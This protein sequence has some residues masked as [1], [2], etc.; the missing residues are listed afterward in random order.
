MCKQ[1]YVLKHSAA[2]RH[3]VQTLSVSDSRTYY[4]N[5]VR[6]C[7]MELS[8]YLSDIYSAAQFLC[9]LIKH[10]SDINYMLVVR[11]YGDVVRI[12]LI[13]CST[14]PGL[15][16]DRRLTF[17]GDIT[18]DPKHRGHGVEKSTHAGCQRRIQP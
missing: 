17:I 2:Q 1:Q 10:G 6:D 18:T 7:I 5:Y 11:I 4:S 14:R 3:S 8:R 12:R 9:N 13:G 16:F 15:Q